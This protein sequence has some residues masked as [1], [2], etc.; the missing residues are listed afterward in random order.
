[1]SI[2]GLLSK[3]RH[4]SAAMWLVFFSDRCSKI[5]APLDFNG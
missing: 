2:L 3:S 5:S 1:L 4:R